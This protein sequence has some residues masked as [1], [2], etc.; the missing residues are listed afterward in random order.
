MNTTIPFEHIQLV[1][2]CVLY[3]ALIPLFILPPRKKNPARFVFSNLEY[4]LGAQK[5]NPGQFCGYNNYED[6]AN[7]QYLRFEYPLQ[8]SDFKDVIEDLLRKYDYEIYSSSLFDHLY[9]VQM[10]RKGEHFRIEIITGIRV[11]NSFRVSVIQL[12]SF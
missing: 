9:S 10:K 11:P 1:T 5:I 4:L 8:L 3:T 2:S 7:R 6:R 12:Y